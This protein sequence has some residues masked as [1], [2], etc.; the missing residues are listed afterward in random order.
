MEK[1]KLLWKSTLDELMTKMSWP[2]WDE[3]R[4]STIIVLV[5]SLIL[6]IIIY[7]LDTTFG[8]VSGMFYNFM[9]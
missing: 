1:I 5:A 8:F 4:T 7:L 3:L 9:E 2:T 6:G